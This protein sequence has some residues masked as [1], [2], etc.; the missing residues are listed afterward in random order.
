MYT[1]TI[2]GVLA[3]LVCLLV[4][5]GVGAC[6]SGPED[7]TLTASVKTKL[8]ADARTSA[9]G[10][11]VTTKDGVVTLTGSVGSAAEKAQAETIAK[12]VEGVKSVTNNLT[13]QA[14]VATVPAASS[15]DAAIKSSVEANLAK[16]SVTGV[17]VRVADGVVYL[18][19][20]VPAASFQKALQAANEAK[21]TPARVQNDLQ[22]A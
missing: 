8:A 19:G 16:Y 17:S 3:G 13:V 21:P 9:T 22:R 12:G 1:R 4:I 2:R 18:T 20:T 14:P 15:N 7:S 6:K 5:G 11:D 10:V